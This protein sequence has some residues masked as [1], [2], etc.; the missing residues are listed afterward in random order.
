MKLRFILTT[1]LLAT[2]CALTS[3]AKGRITAH[4]G[5]VPGT[6]NF[7]LYEPASVVKG[8]ITNPNT[9]SSTLFKDEPEDDSYID[10]EIFLRLDAEEYVPEE[11]RPHGQGEFVHVDTRNGKPVVIFLHGAS[12][13]GN[14]LNRVRR[15]G[16]I[17]AIEGGR[18]MD[19]YVIAPQNPGGAWS[20]KK[21]MAIVDWLMKRGDVDPNRIYALGMSLGGYG[22][23]DLAATY[24][25][26]IAAAIAMCGGAS[27]RNL[28]GLTELPLWII[29]GT[30][31]AAVP[32][33][34]SD[35]V[36]SAIKSS[37]PLASRL[38]Y[39][40]VPGMNHGQ[41]ARIFYKPETYEW[42]FS[43]NL[44]DPGRPI[45]PGFDV[46]VGALTNAYQGLS[47][48]KSSTSKKSKK[49]ATR[50]KKSSRRRR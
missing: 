36:V 29:H 15:Y 49:T 28:E 37:D 8:E 6:Y 25:D 43:H 27:V 19:A 22:T 10:T 50:R 9:I 23:I 46:S 26:R 34:Q 2:F 32:V 30:A 5:D 1:L 33:S 12:L 4:R 7:W 42:L 39:N 35:K 24:P 31:D 14:D 11:Y 17:T 47:L 13:C 44:N 41:P 40:R 45:S 38:I 21:I 3:S 18:D 48:R 16:T 20:P